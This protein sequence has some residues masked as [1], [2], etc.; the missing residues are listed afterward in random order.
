[1]SEENV[2]V[3]R[4]AA[5]A[6]TRGDLDTWAGYWADEI[7]YRAVEGAPDDHGPIHGKDALRAY[8]QDWQE[9]FDDFTAEQIE[10]IDAGGDNVI[11]VIRSAAAPS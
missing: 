6:L 4:T 8:V 1:M 3:V 9:T 2:A 5:E 7:D 10:L 11:A